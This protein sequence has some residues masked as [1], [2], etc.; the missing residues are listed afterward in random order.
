MG[1][2]TL[3]PEITVADLLR[4]WPETIP[5]FVKH[6]MACVGCSVSAFETVRGVAAV[7][8]LPFDSFL[9]ELQEV[10]AGGQKIG[11]RRRRSKD[12]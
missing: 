2:I 1:R 6:R 8:Q 5:V 10:A 4:N 9:E 11:D 12:G 7:Y 3:T